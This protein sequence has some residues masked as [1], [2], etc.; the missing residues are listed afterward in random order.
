MRARARVRLLG[1]AAVGAAAPLGEAAEVR[2]VRGVDVI[3]RQ[4]LVR[5]RDRAPAEAQGGHAMRGEVRAGRRRVTVGREAARGTHGEGPTEGWGVEQGRTCFVTSLSPLAAAPSPPS[6]LAL[7]L[8]KPSQ[9]P[10]PKLEPAAMAMAGTH[11][12]SASSRERGQMVE[13]HTSA[14]S[15]K[16]MPSQSL[17]QWH[18]ERSAFGVASSAALASA[19]A[20][21]GDMLCLTA[22]TATA[23]VEHAFST[24]LMPPIDATCSSIF[25]VP[26]GHEPVQK[27]WCFMVAS[28]WPMPVSGALQPESLHHCARQPR[29]A[30]ALVYVLYTAAAC[31]FGSGSKPFPICQ[32]PRGVVSCGSAAAIFG[33]KSPSQ[34]GRSK[35]EPDAT[36][37][38]G[39]HIFTASS[40]SSAHTA[41][42]HVF[43]TSS[44][45][46]PM[47]V[48]GPS[49]PSPQWHFDRST[50]TLP[51][52][53]AACPPSLELEQS[54]ALW[55]N[56]F[57]ILEPQCSWLF[58]HQPHSPQH[59]PRPPDPVQVWPFLSPQLLSPALASLRQAVAALV[60]PTAG[61]RAP[62]ALNASVRG[63]DGS[64]S[65][66][67]R[68]GEHV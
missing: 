45:V 23:A 2:V 13:T 29:S 17:P 43:A 14:T 58:P 53:V 24:A 18:F 12:L 54:P 8:K 61:C 28:S 11:M 26:C 63:E 46:S 42:T 19:L 57:C 3:H 60:L 44:I 25:S 62:P 65:G 21:A 52:P 32:M 67:A 31:S 47:H 68:Q 27:R 10:A 55:L 16:V 66:C 41:L 22:A 15:S 48:P 7:G 39:T 30:S 9:L 34:P 56:S 40:W 4:H 51:P 38:A 33:W 59:E 64:P 5:V 49:G 35:L 37:T 20:S 50:S 6:P 36:I 1:H